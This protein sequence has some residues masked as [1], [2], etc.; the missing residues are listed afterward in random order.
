M[1]PSAQLQQWCHPYLP[2]LDFSAFYN[3]KP[4]AKLRLQTECKQLQ[5]SEKIES[6]AQVFL[7]WPG[8]YINTDV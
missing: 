2:V 8:W 4:D 3:K 6:V 5:A 1:M 7:V